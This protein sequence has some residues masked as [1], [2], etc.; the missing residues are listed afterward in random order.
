M[1]TIQP[2]PGKKPITWSQS[3]KVP[4]WQNLAWKGVP[5]GYPRLKWAWTGIINFS[6][7]WPIGRPQPALYRVARDLMSRLSVELPCDAPPLDY[8]HSG[9]AWLEIRDSVPIG[10]V[11][12]C[13]EYGQK[14][15][16]GAWVKPE[17]RRTGV[18]FRLMSAVVAKYGFLLVIRPSKA[19]SA[20]MTAMDY[21]EP[22]S[23]IPRLG[24][25]E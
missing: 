15:I 1:N 19:M 7:Y 17:F 9:E 2:P 5:D 6:T 11:T 4:K 12:I 25:L 16:L 13:K 8:S 3:W 22:E 10:C 21:K 14:M 24:Q 18:M 23:P 20:W